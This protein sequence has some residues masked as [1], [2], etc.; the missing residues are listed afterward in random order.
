MQFVRPSETLRVIFMGTAAIAVPTLEALAGA[1]DIVCVV[2]QPDRPRGRGRKLAPPPVKET[3]DNLGLRVL[4]PPRLREPSVVTTLTTLQPD[5]IVVFAFGQILPR[6]VLDIPPLG[7][8]NIHPS[9]LP[10]YRG[11]APVNWPIINGDAT[12][13]VTTM[14][15]DEGMDTG[16]IL[17]SEEVPIEDDETAEELAPRLAAVA[18]RLLLQTLERWKEGSLAPIPQ[19]HARATY[20]PLLKK[21]DGLIRWEQDAETIRNQ[22]RGMI[23]WPVAY[24]LWKGKRLRVYRTRTAAGEGTPG[25]VLSVDD[26]VEVACAQGSLRVDELQL[27]GSRRMHWEEFLRGR[28]LTNGDYLG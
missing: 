15:M 19:N 28:P 22:V 17:L 6:A 27:E 3:A 1:E 11:A 16:D 7:C 12:T 24:T 8:I 9:L 4:Q 25:R 23:P 18:S 2:T 10:R 26:G 21:D 13:G 14:F 20:A 5:L